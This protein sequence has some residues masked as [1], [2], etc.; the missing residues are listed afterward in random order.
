[1]LIHIL[2][3][4]LVESIQYPAPRER[5]KPLKR[6][7]NPHQRT[8][9]EP[10]TTLTIPLSLVPPLVLFVRSPAFVLL[11]FFFQLAIRKKKKTR[12]KGRKEAKKTIEGPKNS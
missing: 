6:L 1:M 11:L 12:T 2:L 8:N 5:G 4:F 10:Y 3:G 9:H 7:P